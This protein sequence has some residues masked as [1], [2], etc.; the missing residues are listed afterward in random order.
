LISYYKIE[1]VENGRLQSPSSL[2]ELASLEISAEY[3]D[4]T[5]F[6]NPP[7]VE[8]G[9]DGVLRYRGEGDELD[10]PSSKP[11][12]PSLVPET[13]SHNKRPTERSAFY[14]G[15][16]PPIKR[17]KHQDQPVASS[18]TTPAPAE[19]ASGTIVLTTPQTST[20]S[21]PPAPSAPLY[22]PD[23][24]TTQVASTYPPQLPPTSG[25]QQPPPPP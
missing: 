7:K 10:S 13:S 22:S 19:A 3:L 21:I 2:P 24:N 23:P 14:H 20:S 15:R 16:P 5:H 8:I 18:S 11:P 6:R 25:Y 4:K 1:D 17:S 12:A 9:T